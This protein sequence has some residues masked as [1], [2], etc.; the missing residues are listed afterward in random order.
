MEVSCPI[1]I[2]RG[3]TTAHCSGRAQVLAT[4]RRV[5]VPTATD[6]DKREGSKMRPHDHKR[7]SSISCRRG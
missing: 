5:A 1:A 4:A 3:T 7:P 6:D 2:A